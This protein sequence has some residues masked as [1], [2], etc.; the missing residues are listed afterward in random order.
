MCAVLEFLI[1]SSV[2]ILSV[3]SKIVKTFTFIEI[4]VKVLHQS[5]CVK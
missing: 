1:H 3:V 4:N 2:Y 5:L